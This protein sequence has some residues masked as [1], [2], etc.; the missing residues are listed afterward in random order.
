MWSGSAEAPATARIA[1]LAP[2]LQPSE[3]RVAEAIA[4][5][6]EAA[7]ERTAQQTADLVGVGRASVTRTAQSLGYDGYPQLRVALARE[8]VPGGQQ[9]ADAHTDRT[10]LGSLRSAVDRFAGRLS[11]SVSA[12]TEEDLQEFVRVIADSQRL[13]I[14]ANGLSSPLGLDFAMRLLSSGRPAEYISD[15]I[16]QQIAAKQL[17]PG[18]ACLVISGS[19]ANRASLEVMTAARASGATVLLITS[20]AHSPAAQHADNALVVVPITD[21]FRD[22]LVHTSRAALMLLTESIVGLLVERQGESARA[23]QSATLSVVSRSLTD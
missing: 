19:G 14:A 13:L 16:G 8:T 5:D 17:G 2:S 6:V 20:F 11:R 4:G 10:M 9:I 15:T 7:I 22:E 18:S 23:A 3:R 1:L 12:L 21:S